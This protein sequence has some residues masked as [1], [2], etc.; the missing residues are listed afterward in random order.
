MAEEGMTF[1]N[2]ALKVVSNGHNLVWV[3][4][5]VSNTT[6]WGAQCA[7]KLKCDHSLIWW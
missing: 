5:H 7:S 2:T 1:Q 6:L 3:K 4:Y